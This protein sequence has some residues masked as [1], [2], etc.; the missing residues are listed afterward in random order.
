MKRIISLT[1]IFV[2]IAID[3]VIK[4][5][6]ILDLKPIGS[7]PIIKEVLHLTYAENTGAAFSSFQGNKILLIYIPILILAVLLVGIMMKKIKT[8][9]FIFTLSAVIAGGAG[10]LIDRIYAGY[11][12]DY[13]DF[14]LIN[15]AIFNFADCCTVVGSILLMV[16]LIFVYKDNPKEA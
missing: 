8:P 13:V 7:V 3:Q 15:F 10:N 2:L 4:R 11:V 16:Y 1:I 6:V 14:R 5:M 9:F 12:V